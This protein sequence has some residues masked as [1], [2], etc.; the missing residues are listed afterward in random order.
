MNILVTFLLIFLFSLP[1]MGQS[2]PKV[3]TAPSAPTTKQSNFTEDQ[4]KPHMINHFNEGCPTNSECSP[5]MGM[6]YKRWVK[7]VTNFAKEKDG[8]RL[9][10]RFRKANGV[11]FEV[12]ATEKSKASEG[13]IFWDSP[14]RNHNIEGKEKIRIGIVMVPHL[15]KLKKLTTSNNIYLR[16]LKI[17]QGKKKKSKTYNTLRGENPLYIENDKLIYQRLEEGQYYGLS[18]DQSGG[19]NIISTKTPPEYPQSIDCPQELVEELKSFPPSENLYAG[20][21]CQKTWNMT[22]KK[23]DILM[24]GWSCN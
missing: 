2:N 15:N 5:E 17:F 8:W 1:S 19:L 16:F 10:E 9:L 18:V 6:L 7:T 12:W 22:K 21:Y 4:F 3:H 20:V 13:I 11:P 24:V 14:C 23:F